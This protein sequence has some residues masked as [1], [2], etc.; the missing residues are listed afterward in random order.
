MGELLPGKKRLRQ[1]LQREERSPGNR[2]SAYGMESF[3][4]EVAMAATEAV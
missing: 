4:N 2:E 3:M 1:S